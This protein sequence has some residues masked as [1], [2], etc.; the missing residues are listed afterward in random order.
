M[1][2]GGDRP[3]IRSF[4]GAIHTVKRKNV[5]SRLV[6]SGGGEEILFSKG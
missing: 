6:G 1:R 3:H 4:R 2:I 5:E